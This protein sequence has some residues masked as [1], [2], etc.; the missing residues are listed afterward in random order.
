MPSVGPSGAA[1]VLAVLI[2]LETLQ[3]L[4]VTAAPAE[5]QDRPYSLSL[6]Y[7]KGSCHAVVV[8]SLLPSQLEPADPSFVVAVVM[9][10]VAISPPSLLQLSSTSSS[11]KTD[12][13]F[14]WQ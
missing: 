10:T 1:A 2:T 5:R 4:T 7:T 14:K 3:T 13:Q 6:S 12:S 11:P 9:A 8:L